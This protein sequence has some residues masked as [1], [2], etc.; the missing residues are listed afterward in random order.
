MTNPF[1]PTPPDVPA[2]LTQHQ[3]YISVAPHGRYFQDEAGRGFIVIGHNDAIT[4]PGFEEL[5][6]GDPAPAEAYIADLRAHGVNVS[7]IMLEYAQVRHGL[8]EDSVGKFAPR[9]VR[10]WDQFIPMAERHGLYLLLTPYDTFWQ[11]LHWRQYPYNHLHGGPCKRKVDWLTKRASIDAQKA[12]WK[13]AIQRWGGSANIFAWDLMNEIDLYWKS[14]PQQLYQYIAEMAS[15]VRALEQEY[16]GKTHLITVSSATAVPQGDLGEVIYNH[17]DLDFI[18][19]HLYAGEGIKAPVDTI[20]GALNMGSAVAASLNAMRYVRPYFDSESGPIDAWILDLNLDAEYHHN[21]SFAHLASGGAGS[22]MRWPYTQLHHLLPPFRDNLLG[23][24]RF[25]TA[26]DWTKFSSRNINN[27]IYANDE[28]VLKM[29]CGDEYRLLLWFLSD[30]RRSLTGSLEGVRADVYDVLRDGHYC[31]EQWET[32]EGRRIH[33]E[34]VYVDG[35]IL[36][37]TLHTCGMALKDIA[38]SVYP[39]SPG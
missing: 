26:I 36:R 33:A 8:L 15:Y 13:F 27:W 22:G 28:T 3:G 23:M 4:W 39:C 30:R 37:F 16:W 9:V 19:T 31:V 25:A 10:F 32:Y 29:G 12:R 1:S 34:R 24:A 7:R 21:M 6:W 17:P 2:F 38:V 11:V 14:T 18:N 5:L 20:E 35:G